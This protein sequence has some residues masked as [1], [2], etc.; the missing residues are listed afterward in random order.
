MRRR[1]LA[2]TGQT[3]FKVARRIRLPGLERFGHAF[4]GNGLQFEIEAA[5]AA[6][7]EGRREHPL[8]PLSRSIAA[9]EIIE[10]IRA[11][12]PLA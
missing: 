7:L 11:K 5:S 6:I 9:L 12:A 10:T 1:L 8:M 3:L 4:P 2:S